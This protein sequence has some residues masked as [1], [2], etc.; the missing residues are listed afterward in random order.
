MNIIQK[1]NN[2]EIT[3]RHNNYQEVT[4]D[5]KGNGPVIN[6][7]GVHT[8][9]GGLSGL[10]PLKQTWLDKAQEAGDIAGYSPWF[11]WAADGVNS[12][13]SLGRSG[14]SAIKGDSKKA[15]EH[16]G[17]AGFRAVMMIPG[18]DF[19]KAGKTLKNTRNVKKSFKD[20][21]PGFKATKLAPLEVG[22]GAWDA[23][24]TYNEGKL[25]KA[26]MQDAEKVKDNIQSV[27]VP[28]KLNFPKIKKKDFNFPVINN[29]PSGG[30][31]KPIGKPNRNFT[32][33]DY[34]KYYDSI[35]KSKN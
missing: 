27:E 25:T 3:P 20:L 32:A 16:L 31:S 11:G 28:K 5:A 18:L 19:V 8:R 35:Q 15:K 9:T 23:D 21:N 26:I 2:R 4:V 10:S 24:Q 1:V 12:L 22:A 33:K 17:D 13:V 6:F 14:Y 7:D 29:K 30:V 34:E